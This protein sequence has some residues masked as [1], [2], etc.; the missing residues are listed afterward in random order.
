MH[1]LS[2]LALRRQDRSCFD[3]HLSKDTILQLFEY[4]L[5]LVM[6][7]LRRRVVLAVVA[8]LAVLH[9]SRGGPYYGLTPKPQGSALATMTYV[10]HTNQIFLIGGLSCTNRSQCSCFASCAFTLTYCFTACCCA[11]CLLTN[12]QLVE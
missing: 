4:N 9:G 10:K 8:L 3:K 7:T 6:R 1:P 12:T 11:L 2:P 5:L